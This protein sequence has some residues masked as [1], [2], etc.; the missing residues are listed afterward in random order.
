MFRPAAGEAF[1]LGHSLGIL[2]E[3][4]SV[5]VR[6]GITD[7]AAAQN[8]LEPRLADLR[9][10]YLMKGMEAAVVRITQAVE[11]GQRVTIFADYD[12]DG[13]TSAAIM[14]ELLGALGL[15]PECV[16]PDRLSEGYGLTDAALSRV[17]A[18]RPDL[19][20]TLDCGISDSERIIRAAE[21][22]IDTI[23]V[24]HHE[25]PAGRFYA[26]AVI[27]PKQP[28][29]EFPFKAMAAVGLAFYLACAV[30][31]RMAG[32]PELPTPQDWL[33]LV[34]LGTIADLAPLK[35]ENRIMAKA[36]LRC[37]E[38]TKRLGLARLKAV[39]RCTGA[40]SSA[41][42]GFRLGPRLNAAGRMG[43]AVRALRLLLT[44]DLA[45]ATQ[46]ATELD[47]QNTQRQAIEA[48]T[49]EECRLMIDGAGP[50]GFSLLVYS[51]GWHP[52][53]L[54]IVASRLA[55]HYWRPTIVMAEENGFWRGSARSIKGLHLFEALRACEHL[56]ERYGGH[57][58]A[59][60]MLVKDENLNT[61]REVFDAYCAGCLSAEDLRPA[62]ELDM[63]LPLERVNFRL[64]EE[65]AALEPHG[66]GNPR[67]LF[68]AAGLTPLSWSQ[69]KETHLKASFFGCNGIRF[70]A[71]GFGL[72]TEQPATAV[73]VAFQPE[74]NTWRGTRGLRL[75]IRA[76]RR[77][78]DNGVVE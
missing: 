45:E 47:G 33:D 76:I 10:P 2:P 61:F 30:R 9:D 26:V 22:G 75:N 39:S 66:I 12:V 20:I 54:G 51:E 8:F 4:A 36:G 34:A 46:L 52:G 64:A 63:E 16:L 70:E 17:L 19:L 15:R 42:V 23:V 29:C 60:G 58:Q 31:T 57:R 55:E 5:L 18:T 11:A 41:D 77:A 43:D 67:P 62:I 53:I 28:G 7:A 25:V 27:N 56:L 35:E 78:G 49:Q 21:A 69:M 24:D 59:A 72:W 38:T 65:L 6:R 50:P 3:V 13:V 44:T 32:R 68:A 40:V 48:A 73:D 37:L 14:L 74:I 71:V 1:D